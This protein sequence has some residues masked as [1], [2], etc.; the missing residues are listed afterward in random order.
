LGQKEVDWAN[1]T[2]EENNMARNARDLKA[3]MMAEAEEAINDL[4]AGASE[5]ENLM[6]SDI[7]RLVR[8]AGKRVMERFTQDLVEA[9]AEEEGSRICPECGQKM[10]YKGQK[11]RDLATET[12][13]VRLERAHYYCPKCR[14]GVFPPRS[15]LGTE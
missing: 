1:L 11:A 7:E 12:G 15:T 4:L 2:Q 5:K 13:E 8:T 9:E 10:R 6:L 3:Q 14:K